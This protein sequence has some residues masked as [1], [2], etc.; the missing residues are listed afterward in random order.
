M[1]PSPDR[2]AGPATPVKSPGELTVKPTAHPLLT[3]ILSGLVLGPVTLAVVWFGGAAFAL[4]LALAGGL[5]AR[6]W[7]RMTARDQA[8]WTGT[9]LALMAIAGLGATAAGVPPGQVAIGLLGGTLVVYGLG[10]T[11]GVQAPIWLAA[12]VVSV[13][14]PCVA[15]VWLRGFRS[16]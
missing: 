13:G 1:A 12:G 4:F 10:R 8:G 14:L 16:C 5:M 6:E 9:A 15:F 3:R 2:P 7:S 11:A